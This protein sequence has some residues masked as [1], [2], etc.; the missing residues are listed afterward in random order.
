MP[1]PWIVIGDFNMIADPRDKNNDRVCRRW[2]NKFRT[3]LNRS[4]L[5]ELPL[6]GRKFTWS[7]EQNSPTLVRL[8]WA[9]ANVDWELMFRAAKLLPQASSISDHC[10]LLL[11]NDAIMTMNKRFRYEAYWEHID[12]FMEL[13]NQSWAAP[14][15][16]RCPLATLNTKLWRLSRKLREWSKSKVGD[17]KQQMYLVNEMALQLDA[18]QDY[19]ILSAKESDVRSKLKERSLG[20]AVLL[21]VKLRQRS[22]VLWLRAGD[23]NTHF[24][25]RKANAR[26]NRST[27]HV[28]HG[29]D[30][31]V[32]NN[33]EM[34][35][36]AINHF[37]NI[38]GQTSS[39]M[40]TLNWE[41]LDLNWVDLSDIEAWNDSS[42][43]KSWMNNR[44]KFAT[45]DR[46]KA[47]LTV[48]QL[49]LWEIWRERNRRLF[50]NDEKQKNVFL[51]KLKDEI[52]HWNMAGAGIPF[53]PG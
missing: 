30:G 40:A 50:S 35:K 9:F 29:P 28:L 5:H 46:R 1:G 12:G 47:I 23:V 44:F 7:N 21:K 33:E 42:D 2:M 3:S 15:R 43:L 16:A 27:I 4:S 41:E 51:A 49:V 26:H 19:R 25:Q 37:F 14:V 38:F 22:R 18:A 36:L 11:R 13:V 48:M 52:H 20:L 17:I 10:P 31:M 39:T 53:D 34:T 24:F 6:I 32:S 8:D 45:A